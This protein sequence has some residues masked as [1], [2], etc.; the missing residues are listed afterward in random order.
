M[1]AIRWNPLGRFKA[2][3]MPCLLLFVVAS[4][5]GL[6]LHHHDDLNAHDNCPACIQSQQG[7]AAPDAAAPLVI[8]LPESS[9]L[10]RVLPTL[11]AC[12]PFVPF[13]LSRG[14][15]ALI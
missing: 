8:R 10:L 13:S 5:I 15:P 4:Q 2:W 3:L 9:S 1:L 14:P 7:F 11:E 12:S 6:S